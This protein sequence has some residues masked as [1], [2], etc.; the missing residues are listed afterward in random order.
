MLVMCDRLAQVAKW[1][2]RN[3]VPLREQAGVLFGFAV[4][5]VVQS[6]AKREDVLRIAV[7][8]VNVALAEMQAGKVTQ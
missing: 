5:A 1:A 4:S 6:G 2:T 3:G 7:D 8:H